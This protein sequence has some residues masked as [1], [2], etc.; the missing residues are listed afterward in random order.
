MAQVLQEYSKLSAASNRAEVSRIL[1][2]INDATTFNLAEDTRQELIKVILSDVTTCA[3]DPQGAQNRL[4]LK[5]LAQATL[6]L[7][8]LGKKPSGAAVFAVPAALS[9]LLRVVN[10]SA[11]KDYPDA[12]S[13]ALRCIANTLLLAETSRTRWISAEVGGGDAS[14]LLLDKATSPVDIFLASRIL[15]LS[16]V[17]VASPSSA[18]FLKR[19]VETKFSNATGTIIDIITTKVDILISA[20]Q[21]A[22]P[23]ARDALTDLLKLAF[24]LLM[25]YPKLVDCE[26]QD[27]NA[28]PTASSPKVMGD[29]WSHDLDGLLPPLLKIFTTL[30]PTSPSPIGA[31]LTHAIHGLITIPVAPLAPSWFG[32]GSVE[33]SR[34]K[35][36]SSSTSAPSSSR[37]SR[38]A[39]RASGSISNPIA[40]G[41]GAGSLSTSS[42]TASGPT[43]PT[44]PSKPG[45]FDRAL[46]ALSAGARSLSRSPSPRQ[47]PPG[48]VLQHAFDIFSASLAYFLPG[49]I[50]PDDASVRQ[51]ASS[52]AGPGGS[53]DA[54]FDELMSPITILITR[55]CIADANSRKRLK[56]WLVP[57]DLDRKEALEGR[58]DTLGRC[59]RLLACVYHSRMKDSVGEMLYAMCD[60]DA[61]SLSAHVGYGNVAG[62][63]FNKGIMNAPPAS[64]NLDAPTT[65]PTGAPI[66][67]ITGTEDHETTN[68]DPEMTEEE[69]E[70][71]A[72]K[73]FVLFDRLERTGALPPSQNPIRKAIQEGKYPAP[74]A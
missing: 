3:S 67:P 37:S 48:D 69:K 22:L 41:S 2:S 53:A 47:T 52:A 31:P 60:S 25:H 40:S 32:T 59:L 56:M 5:D 14:V 61:T 34:K 57:P 64:A 49:T 27:P 35:K 33:T 36:R 6:A 74:G 19:L 66:N 8:T 1:G 20:M 44:T 55:L 21:T 65:S 7:K 62:F 43:S 11:L 45:A 38:S 50:D 9:A 39:S 12:S 23:M 68:N 16:T 72:E 63:L 13:E 42:G 30:P 24:N 54:S 46:S 29:Y 51:R 28:S 70:R 71:E 18:D 15:F 26:L 4:S 58:D 10:A 17:F 73:L